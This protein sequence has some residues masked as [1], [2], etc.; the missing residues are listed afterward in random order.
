VGSP[1][2]WTDVKS[3]SAIAADTYNDTLDNQV[4]YY[5]IGIKPGNYTSGTA[6]ATL[7]F[8]SGSITG[9][10]RV[11][12]YTD[13]THVNAAVLTAL[14]GTGA[15][16]DWYEGSWSAQRSWPSTVRLDEGRLWWFGS[17]IYGS[18][19]DDYENFDDTVLGDSGPISRSIGEGPLDVIHWAL[20]LQR[21]MLGTTTAEF[22]VR[23]SALDEP[24]TPTNFI[25]RASSTQGSS[26][27]DAVRLDKTG[28]FVDITGQRIFQLELDIYSYDYK[29]TE[30]TVLVPDL[31]EAG[32]IRLAVQRKPDTRLHVLRVDGTVGVMVFD[33]V[34]NVTCWQDVTTS[35]SVED[36]CI[37][38]GTSEDQVYYLVRRTIN[39][40]TVRYHEKWAQESECTGLP[41]AKHADAHVI[42]SGAATTTI[43]GLSHLEGASVVAWGWNTVTP[44]TDGNGNTIGRDLGVYTVTSGQITGLPVAVTNA[45]VGLGFTAQWL[46]MKQAF[47]AALG[48]P[49]N[50]AKRIDRLGLILR[51]THA[52]GIQTGPDFD[53]LDD[54]PL[55]DLPRQIA[56]D[57]QVDTHTILTD[58]DR[59]MTAF[60]D[61]WSTD[62]RVAIQAVA[63]R[64]A[65]ALA[66]TVSMSTSG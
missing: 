11:T 28:I 22:S 51:N 37:L 50:Q 5:R 60:N 48:T 1:G 66:F 26:Y 61:V 47:A 31:N 24:L 29:S 36:V 8:S 21:L 49:L 19:S 65:S 57:T 39:G 44:F 16:T 54:L 52:L 40:A 38:P 6:N 25:I 58:Y 59:Q 30:L 13:S 41:V 14:G 42:Y 10:V 27:V 3:Y 34:E 20:S 4:I 64:P 45:C 63:P 55:A 7:T 23:S 53:N 43:T 32:I 9:I 56:D 18:I 2:A 33:A 35:G 46:S 17:M 12:G 62:S 15:T